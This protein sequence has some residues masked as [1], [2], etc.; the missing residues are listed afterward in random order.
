MSDLEIKIKND[1][2]ELVVKECKSLTVRDYRN[3]LIMQD[4]L[5]KGDE[6]EHVKLDKQLTFMASLFEDLTVD[7]LYD[8]YNMYEL[9]NALASLYVKLIG[10]EP[11]DPKETT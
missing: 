11:E 6:P 8:K 1:N 5:A 9:N 4:E 2:G 3:Y 7:M 10:G